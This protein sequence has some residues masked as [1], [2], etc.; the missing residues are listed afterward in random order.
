MKVYLIIALFA[1]SF[2][3]QISLAQHNDHQC[4]SDHVMEKMMEQD[5][6]FLRKVFVLNRKISSHTN[7]DAERNNDI[8]S[9]PVVVHVIHE[10]EPI[11]QGSNISDAQVISAIDGLT[12]DFRRMAGTN[13]DG[14]GVDCKI[15][16]CLSKR[17]PDGDPT[18]G[19]VRIDG[20]SVPLYAEQGIRAS[21]SEGAIESDVK[22]L[23]TWPRE[24]YMNIWVVNEIEDNNALNGIQGY[25]YFPVEL[26]IDG[27][28]VLHNAFGTVGNLKPNTALNRTTSHEA[29]HFFGLYHTFH[30]T[31]DCSAE[32]DCAT[33]GDRVCDTP[34]TPLSVSCT[35]PA[36]SGTQQVENYMDYTA[37]SCRNMFSQGQKDRMRATLELERTSL[38]SSV[39]CVP[40]SDSDVSISEVLSPQGSSC[41][42]LVTPEVRLTNYG[43]QELTSAE[44]VYGIDFNSTSTFNWAGNLESGASIN[45]ELP[46]LSSSFGDHTF[47]ASAQSPNG[48]ADE[49]PGNNERLREFIIAS[50][51][52][53]ELDVT[54]D[55]FG[56]ET[57]W[58]ISNEDGNIIASGGPYVNSNQGLVM[59]EQI[60]VD[61][62][63][64]TLTVY[65]AYGDGMGFTSGTFELKDEDGSSLASGG[66]DFG[67]ESINE[68]CIDVD[69][70]GSSPDAGFNSSENTVCAGQSINFSDIS[71]NAPTSWNWTFEGGSPSTSSS[72]NPQ[73]IS[74]PSS[75]TFE[76]SLEVSNEHGTDSFAMNI[77]VADAPTIVI[78]GTPPLCYGQNTGSAIASANGSGLSYSWNNGQSGNTLLGIGAGNYTVTVSNNAGCS[79][80]ESIQISEPEAINLALTGSSLQCSGDQNGS[81]TTEVSG[82]VTP[83]SYLWNNGSENQNLTNLNAGSYSLTVTDANGC[84][85]QGSVNV[86]SPNQLELGLQVLDIS[87]GNPSGSASIS[88]T[89]GAAPYTIIWSTGSSQ[90][91][92]ENLSPE[93]YSVSIFDANSCSTSQNFSINEGSSLNL[94]ETIEHVS[95]GATNNGS[96]AISILGGSGDY[97]I[98]WDNGNDG[99]TIEGLSPGTYTINVIDSEGCIGED[100]YTIEDSQAIQISVF[101]TD[102][103]C[104]GMNNG[105]AQATISGGQAPYAISW[106][107]GDETSQTS[108]LSQGEYEIE[109]IDAANCEASESVTIIEPI[110]LTVQQLF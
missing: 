95:C 99:N 91:G 34:L 41:S 66:G 87:C 75:G 62:G 96:I 20:S 33:Q 67:S 52:T 60:C 13:G 12:E 29:G 92:V 103:S 83:Y 69:Q 21:G 5:E 22:A 105:S 110:E 59:T 46:S 98:S 50:G 57:T 72:Q 108:G 109:V 81:I 101:K 26:D 78:S 44:I 107:N 102:I 77:T 74:F 76:A 71:S 27:I 9:I 86:S 24:D 36:C 68:F 97:D 104:H 53:I 65:D 19:I 45:I 11:G 32:I 35:S 23:S 82:G 8:Y 80:Q 100:T 17:T 7:S 4:G 16:F 49:N 14:D 51:T 56:A 10:G 84:S 43:N 6:T 55:Y 90:Y 61:E 106:S 1:L 93:N 31:Q 63:C 79:S 30:D 37:E 85:S 88:P 38:L 40:I 15:E 89:G 58:D 2:A 94:I 18:N 25:A 70:G 73:N 54:L 3:P 39:G 64:Y 42:T 28:V 47:H 48:M